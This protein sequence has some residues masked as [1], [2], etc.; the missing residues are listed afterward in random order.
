MG[1]R[2]AGFTVNYYSVGL[3]P[4]PRSTERSARPR[5]AGQSV[6][7]VSRTLRSWVLRRCLADVS[8]GQMGGAEGTRTPDP[9]TASVGTALLP[10][11]A[12]CRSVSSRTNDL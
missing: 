2:S 9:H 1:R 12:R 6:T 4:T 7:P 10:D 8:P 5:P 11:D 3:G